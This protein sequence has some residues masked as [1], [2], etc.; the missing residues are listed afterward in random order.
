MVEAIRGNDPD[1][2][3]IVTEAV[4]VY[5]NIGEDRRPENIQRKSNAYSE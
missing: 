2:K 5:V 1:E 3:V 4:V